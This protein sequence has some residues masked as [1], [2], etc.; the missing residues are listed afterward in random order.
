[1]QPKSYR[2][3]FQ[4]GIDRQGYPFVCYNGSGYDELR[5]KI[6]DNAP[7]VVSNQWTH[8]AAIYDT[9]NQKLKLYRNGL[10]ACSVVSG[11][12]PWNGWVLPSTFI[13]Y[14]T[15]TIGAG[16]ADPTGEST[17]LNSYF[18]GKID[19]VAVWDGA[20]SDS[21]LSSCMHTKPLGTE[22]NLIGYWN[23][24]NASALD[25]TTNAIHGWFYNSTSQ[26]ERIT[27]QSD[28]QFDVSTNVTIDFQTVQDSI[29][30]VE[31]RT[32]L[33]EGGWNAVTTNMNG[34]GGIIIVTDSNSASPIRFYQVRSL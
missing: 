3:N 23:F 32:N 22:S 31:T 25:T 21:Q 5:I 26:M 2:L 27:Y 6:S 13:S 9:A 29:Y 34:T 16:N 30:V 8:V 17:N 33:M 12:L 18:S 20:F 7:A 15:I 28:I 1:M 4:L 10:Q 24:D 14:G 11:E 19:E